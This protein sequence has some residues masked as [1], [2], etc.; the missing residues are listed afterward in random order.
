VPP[1]TYI[2]VNASLNAAAAPTVSINRDLFRVIFTSGFISGT[3]KK[4][5]VSVAY[6]ASLTVIVHSP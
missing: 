3:G 6:P 5:R 1:S 2:I 4:V